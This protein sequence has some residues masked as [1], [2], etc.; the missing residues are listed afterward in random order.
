M[1]LTAAGE[2]ISW[3]PQVPSPAQ[4][5]TVGWHTQCF[6]RAAP[7]DQ[8]ALQISGLLR[9]GVKRFPR[10]DAYSLTRSALVNDHKPIVRSERLI[11][12]HRAMLILELSCDQALLNSVHLA[13]HPAIHTA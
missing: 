4:A 12:I 10:V 6:A 5:A 7:V 2:I 11:L 1:W 13:F 8:L 3:Q 9:L